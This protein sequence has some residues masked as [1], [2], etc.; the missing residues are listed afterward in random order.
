MVSID[1]AAQL[2]QLYLG[3][4]LDLLG[5]P[6]RG[7]LHLSDLL[8]GRIVFAAFGRQ[9]GVLRGQPVVFRR[10]LRR[11]GVL[12]LDL[13][14]LK[15]KTAFDLVQLCADFIGIQRHFAQPLEQLGVLRGK[16][17]V[18]RAQLVHRGLSLG[19]LRAQL[20]G[21]GVV[22]RVGFFYVMQ[23]VLS[24]KAAEGWHCGIHGFAR[25]LQFLPQ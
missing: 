3:I 17:L 4:L 2:L 19:Q 25:P 16:R 8:S 13:G 7:K 22:F 14:R 23:Y 24:V 20:G 21:L 10:K 5:A 15:G 9:L 6:V 12:R 1:L 18:L 11:T